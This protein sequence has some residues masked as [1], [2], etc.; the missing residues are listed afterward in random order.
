MVFT[1]IVR[2]GAPVVYGGFTSNVD[3]QSGS[4]AF[5]T[6][7]YVRTAML[8]GQLARRYKVP[9]RSSN[10]CA[11]NAVDAQAAYES[12]FSLWGAVMGGV[13][14]SCTARADGGR[15]ARAGRQ[16]DPRRRPA[17][18]GGA[19][20]SIRSSSTRT[21]WRSM[22]SPR[23]GRR[24]LLRRRAHPAA[25]PQR[26]LPADDLGLAQLRDLGRGRAAGGGRPGR[27]AGPAL[28]RRLRAPADGARRSARSSKATLPGAP[29][30]AAFPPIT[31][32][33]RNAEVLGAGRRH[34]RRGGRRQRAL[35]PHQ[36]R[37]DRRGA[38]RAARAHLRLDV[39]RGW[40]HAHAERRPQRLQ[41]AAVH[42]RALQ[43]DRSRAGAGLHDPPARRADA[44]RQ[45]RAPR[46]AADGAGPRAV[47]RHGARDHHGRRGQALFP[48]W[49]TSTS[50]ARCSTPSRA[51]WT[52]P[53]SP[54]PTRFVPG[55]RGP[56]WSA[57]RW[58]PTCASARTGPGT[59]S[60]T[61]ARSTPSTSSTPAGCGPAR[62]G[63]WSA[64]SCPC[65]PWSMRTPSRS[66]WPRSRP[67]RP[68]R[69]RDADGARL[70]R[71]DLHQAGAGRDAARDLRAGLRALVP[72]GHAVDFEMQLLEP[73]LDRIAV[74][75][76][77][78]ST[79]RPRRRSSRSSTDRSCSRPTAIA[80]RAGAGHPQLLGGLR[81]DGRALQA[82]GSAWLRHVDDRGR[83]G[84]RHLGHGRRALRRLRH[85]GVHQ[86][87]GAENP[88]AAAS[89]SRS[90]TRSR[91]RGRCTRRR[92]TT[93]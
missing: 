6:P 87:Q 36:G 35:P 2:P 64:S 18:H 74:A 24:P 71:R 51:M 29:P 33:E 52:P 63:A 76:D 43:G 79:T 82:A 75:R 61:A 20:S 81:G 54:T 69:P 44:G 59:S 88:A 55:T 80:G 65:W 85:A 12:V 19:R 89:A 7:E 42:D 16:A 32:E 53:A 25:L 57:T 91:R 78:S 27:G 4:P 49:R 77:R 34:R 9:Y 37:V 23:S 93:A 17:G 72:A 11:A 90:P 15:P 13:N 67:Q 46:L 21:R 8:G 38:G 22:P 73:D 48:P 50:S 39:A 60:P 62:S 45:P 47:P 5:G 31:S 83:P 14:F 1:Q 10:V 30:R 86:R 92:S 26:V 68:D 84:P 40:W 41:A 66:R 70:R 58:S 28:P 3:M 56:R